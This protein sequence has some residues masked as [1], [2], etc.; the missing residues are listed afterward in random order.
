MQFN[1]IPFI[2][3]FLPVFLLVYFCIRPELRSACLVL[4]S[5]FFYGLS[6]GDQLWWVPMLV[7]VAMFTYGLGRRLTKRP[8]PLALGLG[9]TVLAGILIFFKIFEGGRYLPAGMSFYLF[10]SAAYLIDVYRGRIRMDGP[11]LRFLEELLLFPKLLSGPIVAPDRLRQQSVACPRSF[12]NIREGL[13]TLIVGL[14]LKVLLANR[15]GG[16]FGQLSV[17]GYRDISTPFAWMALISWAMQL[18]FDFYGYS[19]MAIGLGKMIG[20]DLP[21]N[22]RDPYASRSVS[23]F[24]RRWHITL[25]AWFREYLY[26]PLG[27]NRTGTFRTIL[28]LAVVWLFTGLWHGLGGNY[29]LW[30]G[31][32]FFFVVNERLWLGGLLKKTRV[33]CHLYTVFAIL[34]TWVPFAVGDWNDMLSFAGRLFGINPGA[35]NPTDYLIWGREYWPVLLAGVIFATPWPGKLWNRLKAGPIADVFCFVLFWVVVFFIATSAQD[36][37]LYFAY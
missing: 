23:E 18:Y 9:L 27:G 37:F 10:Q 34:L 26:I 14:G 4:F 16:L 22:F 30:A 35:F 8:G 33:L 21:E 13:L 1:S 29:L 7:A 17:V 11:V 5:L 24:Y 12:D 31:M 2:F 15:L 25:G 36:P 3:C 20:Y 19:L 32:I 6:A 28:N